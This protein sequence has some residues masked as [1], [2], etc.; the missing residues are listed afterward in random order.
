MTRK[1]FEPS[2]SVDASNRLVHTHHSTCY[3]ADCQFAVGPLQL[4]NCFSAVFKLDKCLLGWRFTCSGVF[5]RIERLDWGSLIRGVW[6]SAHFTGYQHRVSHR[7]S[8]QLCSAHIFRP[9]RHRPKFA[10]LARDLGQTRRVVERSRVLVS[11]SFSSS[12]SGG[13]LASDMNSRAWRNASLASVTETASF[14]ARTDV[15]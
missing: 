3:P 10:F 6:Q 1:R 12:D 2:D 13:P 9:A 15:P 5:L 8:A 4:A 14:P 7:L 11:R